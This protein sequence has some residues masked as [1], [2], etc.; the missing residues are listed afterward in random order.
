MTEKEPTLAE[1][2][3]AVNQLIV[4]AGNLQYTIKIDTL[5]LEQ[6]NRKILEL[7]QKAFPLKQ[8]EEA[9]RLAAAAP[10]TPLE[11]AIAAAPPA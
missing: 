9:A 4:N 2:E 5:Q 7:N 3:A 8:A 1:L 11:E 10:A 6:I